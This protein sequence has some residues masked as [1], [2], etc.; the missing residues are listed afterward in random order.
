MGSGNMLDMQYTNSKML[1]PKTIPKEWFAATYYYDINTNMNNALISSCNTPTDWFTSRCFPYVTTNPA[2][3]KASSKNIIDRCNINSPV[4]NSAECKT[5]YSSTISNYDI[6]KSYCSEN[7]RFI[8]DQDC[9]RIANNNQNDFKQMQIDYCLKDNQFMLEPTCISI[10]NENPTIF[11]TKQIDYCTANQS[12][13]MS[14]QCQQLVN[15]DGRY[16]N[17]FDFYDKYCITNKNANTDYTNCK[18]Y[19]GEDSTTANGK[20]FTDTLINICSTPDSKLFTDTLCTSVGPHPAYLDAAIAIKRTNLCKS[21]VTNPL[22]TNEIKNYDVYGNNINEYCSTN[23]FKNILNPVC[24]QILNSDDPTLPL[25]GGKLTDPAI[26]KQLY[27]TKLNYCNQSNTFTSDSCKSWIL[28]NNNINEYDLLLKNNCSTDINKSVEPCQTINNP[29]FSNLQSIPQFGFNKTIQC[30][31]ANG[32]LIQN[33]ECLARNIQSNPYYVNLI[34]PTMKSCK[35]DI[36]NEFCTKYVNDLTNTAKQNCQQ[37]K[38][39]FE[40]KQDDGYSWWI[41]ILLIFIVISIFVSGKISIPDILFL[42]WV[43]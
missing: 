6:N 33:E 21:D 35:E 25:V 4:L 32:K 29:L 31:D 10:A 16:P 41:I 13:W 38:S 9:L 22:C 5:V 14:K 11:K 40:D 23:S 36:T 24:N 15:S 30:I 18:T 17:D 7:N 1:I 39:T 43:F 3:L 19:Y 26:Q 28:K 34:E 2:L 20:R 27:T 12:N 8:T 37:I 42:S